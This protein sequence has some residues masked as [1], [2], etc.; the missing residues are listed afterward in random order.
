MT[1][2]ML[3]NNLDNKGM[4]YAKY[5]TEW[6][7]EFTLPGLRT[8]KKIPHY[9][10]NKTLNTNFLQTNTFERIMW[11]KQWHRVLLYN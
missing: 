5:K 10:I 3:L 1:K 9:S 6:L 4:E 8:G 7:H 11:R 2:K